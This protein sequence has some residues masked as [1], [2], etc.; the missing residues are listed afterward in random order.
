[1][2][3]HVHAASGEAKFWLE[4][5]IKLER[6]YG[7]S[8]RQIATAHLLIQEHQSEIRDSWKKHFGG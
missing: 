2:H 4:P 5:E 6:N 1:M 8:T 7:L 3:V